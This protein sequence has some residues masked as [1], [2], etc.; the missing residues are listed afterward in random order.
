MKTTVPGALQ[1]SVSSPRVRC[2]RQYLTE[3]KEDR[4]RLYVT[5]QLLKWE[6]L[7]Q[8]SLDI[9]LMKENVLTI[10]LQKSQNKCK[11]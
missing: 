9:T 4:N 7:V 6:L 5:A 11:T 10:Q 2:Q 1:A 3:K 8:L